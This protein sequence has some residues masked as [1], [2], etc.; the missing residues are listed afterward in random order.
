VGYQAEGTL[1][2]AI[3]NGEKKVRLLG[4]MRDVRIQTPMINGFSAHADQSDLLAWCSSMQVPDQVFLV[5]GEKRSM[6]GFSE[7]LPSIGWSNMVMP[8]LHETIEL[9]PVKGKRL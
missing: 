6:T 3:V 5:H 4:E 8:K 2:R 1:G 9:P 7:K